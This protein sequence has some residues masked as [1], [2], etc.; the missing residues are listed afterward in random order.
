MEQ[1][2]KN[3]EPI[4]S[5]PEF[6]K[7]EKLLHGAPNIENWG[8]IKCNPMFEK[9]RAKEEA[10]RKAKIEA[11]QRRIAQEQSNHV[12]LEKEATH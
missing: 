1:T 9:V 4:Q 8:P 11:V 6:V 2:S 10:Q 5:N 3:W 12:L 7:V